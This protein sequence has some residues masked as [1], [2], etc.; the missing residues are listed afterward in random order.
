MLNFA[1]IV[2]TG[3]QLETLEAFFAAA[4]A[5]AAL[6]AIA[7]DKPIDSFTAGLAAG[8]AAM[9]KPG[10]LAV[11]LALAVALLVRHGTDR[12]WRRWFKHAAALGLGVAVPTGITLVYA[13]KSGAW[14]YLPDVVVQIARYASDTPLSRRSLI[15]MGITFCVLL[16]PL[17]ARYA[18][19]PLWRGNV[20]ASPIRVPP[21]AAICFIW[22]WLAAELAAVLLQRRMYQYHFLPLACPLAL[23]YGMLPRRSA[24]PA[25]IF[26][27]LLPVALL[28][29]RWQGSDLAR[30]GAAFHRG[31]ASQYVVDHTT[32]GQS[33]F[34]DQIGGLLIESDRAPGSRYGTFFYFVNYD[35]A[36]LDFCRGMLADFE[37][38]QPAYILLRRDGDQAPSRMLDGPILQAR[39][40]RRKNFVRA[41]GRFEK[42]LA[43]HYTMEAVVEGNTIYRRR[44][45]APDANRVAT[46]RDE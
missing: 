5:L 20:R 38:R 29:L 8:V 21:G 37:R 13:I 1:C 28:G 12:Q 31:A 24:L 3:F 10:G 18:R 44:A 33:V 17:V 25:Q 41:W 2:F 6:E 19:L 42:Y 43:E 34:A 40:E 39:P 15:K 16:V 7:S 11:V 4:G 23:L 35:R 27:G 30:A 26:L 14:A 22:A 45:G 9:L 46:I 36:P 32:A